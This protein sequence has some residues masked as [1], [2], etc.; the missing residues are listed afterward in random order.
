MTEDQIKR[1][2]AEISKFAE[3]ARKSAKL[4]G[5][6]A[7]ANGSSNPYR[8]EDLRAIWQD[9]WSKADNEGD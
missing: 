1:N 7:R 9:G 3:L 2:S 6:L 4:E 5:Y 8:D